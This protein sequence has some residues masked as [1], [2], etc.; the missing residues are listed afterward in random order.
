MW[1]IQCDWRGI[2]ST[3]QSDSNQSIKHPGIGS[4]IRPECHFL[5]AQSTW[6]I[7]FCEG[8]VCIIHYYLGVCANQYNQ[9]LLN[10]QRAQFRLLQDFVKAE[11]HLLPNTYTNLKATTQPC[12]KLIGG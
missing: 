8:L 6:Q 4:G 10:K 1:R 2:P 3:I 9:L 11:I 7:D 12:V 5:I